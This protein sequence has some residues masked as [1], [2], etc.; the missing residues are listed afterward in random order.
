MV[1]MLDKR[2]ENNMINELKLI[3]DL[4]LGEYDD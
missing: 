1:F 3:N 4:Q 2:G